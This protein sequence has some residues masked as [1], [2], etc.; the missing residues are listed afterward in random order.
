MLPSNAVRLISEYSKPLTRPDW[1]T[2]GKIKM[3]QYTNSLWNRMYITN[4]T[5]IVVMI[6]RN[7]IKSDLFII[8]KYIYNNGTEHLGEDDLLYIQS[9]T[10]LMLQQQHHIY[11]NN[12]FRLIL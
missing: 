3:I 5:N 4:P 12:R 7:L 1:R 2:C 6:T 9:N 10:Y 11:N 8:A